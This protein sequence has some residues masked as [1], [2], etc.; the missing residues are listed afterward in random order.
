MHV[1]CFRFEGSKTIRRGSQ[2]L[3]NGLQVVQ[4]L[5]QAEV[6]EIVAECFQVEKS[7][8]LLV[9]AQNGIFAA[10]PEDMM[11]VLDLLQYALQFAAQFLIDPKPKYRSD[12]VRQ[13]TQQAMSQE[14]SNSLLMGKLRKKIRFRQYSTC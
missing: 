4:R 3:A 2:L 11:A 13:H 14:R 1:E 12:L 9:H 7:G 10:S 8:E 5:F 6:F